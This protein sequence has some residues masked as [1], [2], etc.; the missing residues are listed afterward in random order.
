MMGEP[1]QNVKETIHS[2]LEYLSPSDRLCLVEF[3]SKAKRT[4]PLIFCSDENI[5]N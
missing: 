4:T 2:M 1:I 5:E 3:G